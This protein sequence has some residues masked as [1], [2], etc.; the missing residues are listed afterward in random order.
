MPYFLECHH[1]IDKPLASPLS[2]YR[3][4]RVSIDGGRFDKGGFPTADDAAMLAVRDKLLT[5][6]AIAGVRIVFS[7][8]RMKPVPLPKVA[9]ADGDVVETFGR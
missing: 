9:P 1:A 6:P 7:D 3:W 4:E 8:D 5:H 2:D